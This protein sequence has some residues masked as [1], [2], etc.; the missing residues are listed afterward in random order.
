MNNVIIISILMD[1]VTE[2]ILDNQNPN[3]T[4]NRNIEKLKIKKHDI[5]KRSVNLPILKKN[6]I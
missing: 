2:E 5:K 3:H 4:C 1:C 6:I